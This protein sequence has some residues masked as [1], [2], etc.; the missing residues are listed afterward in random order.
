MLKCTPIVP[1]FVPLFSIGQTAIFCMQ[2]AVLW[3]VKL[4]RMLDCY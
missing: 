1:R 3:T 4:A 2:A